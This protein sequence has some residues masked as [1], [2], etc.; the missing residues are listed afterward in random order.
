WNPPQPRNDLLMG[1]VPHFDGIDHWPYGLLFQ[2][3][4]SPIPKLHGAERTIDDRGRAAP[5][6]LA[7][8]SLGDG[9]SVGEGKPRVVAVGA[10][11]RPIG[12]KAPIKKQQFA[13][14]N[15]LRH[16]GIVLRDSQ[17]NDIQS[18]WDS[19]RER[20]LQFVLDLPVWR[21]FLCS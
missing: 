11:D 4:G 18:P 7:S 8:Y 15:L 6:L 12:G 10:R 3:R 2:R 20:A 5:P 14:F 1:A 17:R 16:Y 19:D 21:W 9:S 13:Q